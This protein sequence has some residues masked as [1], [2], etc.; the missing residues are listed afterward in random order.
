MSFFCLGGGV[1]T[2]SVGVKNDSVSGVSVWPVTGVVGRGELCKLLGLI[3]GAGDPTG[4]GE[5]ETG[6]LYAA[7]AVSE[8]LV[9]H[10]VSGCVGAL[11]CGGLASV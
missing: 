4:E 1:G 3:L 9:D 8:S 5:K 2:V 6:D 11:V 7:E 10:V